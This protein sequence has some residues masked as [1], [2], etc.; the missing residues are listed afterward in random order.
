MFILREIFE[1]VFFP[2]GVFIVLLVTGLVLL[3][4]RERAGKAV[5]WATAAAFYVATLGVFA[6]VITLPL[7]RFPPLTVEQIRQS[8]AQAIVVL[9]AGRKLPQPEYAGRERLGPGNTERVTYAAYL[10]RLTGLPVLVSGGLGNAEREPLAALMADVLVNELGVE[11]VWQED[12]ARNTF[13]H[14]VYC[15][16][17]LA[18]KG[19]EKVLLVTHA[20]HMPRAMDV[21]AQTPIT[22]VAAPTAFYGA[23][24]KWLDVKNWFPSVSALAQLR[25]TLHEWIGLVWYRL[26]Y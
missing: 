1:L 5:L 17:I 6:K 13:E 26:R 20:A 4:R 7:E 16:P 2:P 8:G 21:F 24:V 14:G 22:A 23:S 18:R 15:P 9:A 3:P 19:V 11:P 12:Q 25:R 10:H